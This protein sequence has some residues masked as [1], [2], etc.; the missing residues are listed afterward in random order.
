MKNAG[1]RQFAGPLVA[2]AAALG[3]AALST[4]ACA[5]GKVG[6]KAPSFTLK[7]VDKGGPI[8][9]DQLVRANGKKGAVLV[10]LSA[11]CPYVAQARQPLAELAKQHGAAFSFAGVNANQNEPADEVKAD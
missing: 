8:T 3:A 1:C 5:E 6:D 11:R 2:L 10:F 4:T 7:P 9:L